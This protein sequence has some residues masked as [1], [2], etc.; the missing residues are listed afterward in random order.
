MKRNM[1]VLIVYLLLSAFESNSFAEEK[2]TV[3]VLDLAAKGV[4]NIVSNAITDIIRSE[5][6]NIANFT[7]V[8]R[9][10]MKAVLEEQG[11]QMTG[12]TDSAC[13]VQFGKILS[14]RRIVVGEV[15][16]IG[17]T[18]VI[19]ARYVD[20]QSGESLFSAT[21]KADSLDTV[22]I[23]ARNLAKGLATK[24]VTGDKEVIIPKT[25]GGYYLRSIVPGWGQFYAE[26][27]VRGY[28]FS[29]LFGLSC[30][31]SGYLVYDFY[32]K[33]SDYDDMKKG[34]P[35][36]KFKTARDD[37]EQAAF[38]TNISFGII[39]AV[40]LAHWVD[41]LLFSRSDFD[42][43]FVMGEPEN[44]FFI[45]EYNSAPVKEQSLA[46]GYILKF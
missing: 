25:T 32:G 7:V 22:D 17:N 31:A 29:V 2:V 36:S 42:Q 27:T 10:Q 43:L 1:A 20:V 35:K 11:L 4:P 39:G 5:F 24:I 45:S 21:D 41:A 33:K 44:G 23:S 38:Y 16:K 28:T 3:A 13:A 46:M 26:N 19:T 14:A 12:C 18:I 8:E 15:N 34:E 6:V 40:Y 37:Y 9:S 30:I